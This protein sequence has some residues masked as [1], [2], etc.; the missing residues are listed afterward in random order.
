MQ[1]REYPRGNASASPFETAA[2][3]QGEVFFPY[4]RPAR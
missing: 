2:S 4:A 1:A 3:R